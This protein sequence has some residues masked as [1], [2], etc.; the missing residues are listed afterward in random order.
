MAE[1]KENYIITEMQKDVKLAWGGGEV[2]EEY[3][4]GKN[5]NMEHV[6]YLDEN[7]GTGDIY[8]ESLWFLSDDKIDPEY[9]K[10]MD[11]MMADFAEKMKDMKPED[12]PGPKPHS[13]PF[14]EL[15]TFFGSDFENPEDLHADIDF[16]IEDE[17]VKI[18]KSS[19][20]FIPAGMKHSPVEMNRM[21]RPVFH[22]SLGFTNSY[23]HDVLI[24]K[25]GEYEGL[26]GIPR[27]MINGDRSGEISLPSYRKSIPEGFI[28]QVTQVNS[29]ILPETNTYCETF[30]IYPEDK[31]GIKENVN[32]ADE[33]SH[34]FKQIIAFFGSDLSDIY[35][36]NGEVEL[37]I[38]GKPYIMNKSFYAVI[39]EG[40]KHGPLIV[41]NVKK[42]IFHY[43]VGN[44]PKYV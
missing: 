11:E 38:Q 13:H 39:P 26:P 27:F 1:F 4:P 23:Y 24:N 17:P 12:M 8:S 2:L 16:Y 21:D 40:V 20:F 7:I 31:T 10:K 28:R 29:D 15:F 30:W 18:T 36:L 6:F 44:I 41:R 32:F 34:P 22:F 19:V 35:K 3:I 5:R 25:G 33:H 14:D 42:P 43:S 9:K 37:W